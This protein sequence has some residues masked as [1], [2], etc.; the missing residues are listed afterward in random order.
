MNRR[1]LLALSGALVAS[2]IAGCMGGSQKPAD[3]TTDP[4]TDDPSKS[5]TTSPIEEPVTGEPNVDDDRLAALAAGNA[6]FALDLYNHLATETGGNQFLSP[7]SISTALAMTYAGAQGGTETQMRETLHYTLGED[8]H[9]VFADVQ[10]A[11]DTRKTTKDPIDGGEVDAFQLAVANAL[12]GKADYPFAENYLSLVEDHYGAGLQHADFANDPDGERQRINEWVA[13]A[14]NDRIEKLLPP[15]SIDPSTVLVLT[16]AI[17]FMATWQFKF[18]PADTED[19]TFTALDGTE[20]T[21]PL[22]SQNLRTNYAST[23]DAEVIELPYIGEKVSMVLILPEKGEFTEFERSLDADQ[24]FG[25]FEELGDASGDLRLPRFEFET[26][27]QLSEVLA[28]LGMP[29]A[30]GTGANFSGMVDGDGG[31]LHID[32]VYHKAFVS[33]DEEGTEAA[34]STAV[35]MVES[36]PSRSFDLTFDR[37]FIF[38]IRDRPTDAVLFF[39]RVV[40][41]GQEPTV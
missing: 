11:L 22:M 25:L 36:M 10:T 26:E 9:P 33:V 32:E 14:T 12:W 34:A 35:V 17:Y 8:V 15:G 38:C 20:S 4:S 29:V 30:F 5:P 31:N 2:A 18:D 27:V 28:E 1:N 40:D 37:P 23:S 39:G 6:A 3:T 7:Y 16:N 24:L 13:N 21:V 41:A 19:R